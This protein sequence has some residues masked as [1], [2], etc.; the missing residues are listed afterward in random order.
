MKKVTE[1]AYNFLINKLEDFIF[2]SHSLKAYFNKIKL[3][4]IKKKFGQNAIL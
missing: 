2:Y 3:Y 1:K 4:H